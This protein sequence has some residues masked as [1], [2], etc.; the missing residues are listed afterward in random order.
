M[1]INTFCLSMHFVCLCTLLNN[2]FCLSI[3]SPNDAFCFNYTVCLTLHFAYLFGLLISVLHLSLR[4]PIS[5]LHL[6]P[7]FKLCAALRFS[8]RIFFS[9]LGAPPQLIDSTTSMR[10]ALFH[11][12]SI[13]I[14]FMYFMSHLEQ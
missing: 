5:A 6:S 11:D 12:L 13:S 3:L 10:F 14:R 9:S 2:T 1:L 4:S 8:L 7:R